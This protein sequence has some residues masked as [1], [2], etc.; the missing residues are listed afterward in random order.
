LG[1]LFVIIFFS[2][3]YIK[4]RPYAIMFLVIPLSLSLI[5]LGFFTLTKQVDIKLDH[6]IYDWGLLQSCRNIP[7]GV[8]CRPAL[9]DALYT[10][11]YQSRVVEIDHLLAL[12]VAAVWG[13][14]EDNGWWVLGCSGRVVETLIGPARHWTVHYNDVSPN[15]F[16]AGASYIRLPQ[17]LPPSEELRPFLE[18]EG[19]RGLAWGGGTWFSGRAG[20][21]QSR[22]F[23]KKRGIVSE[24]KGTAYLAAP[25]SWKFPDLITVNG[26][27]YT[28]DSRG[29][30]V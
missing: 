11:W 3:V 27:N 26:P 6:K 19:L 17:A 18:A 9:G 16:F 20:P 29:D 13:A 21:S 25:S 2:V 23:H 4:S 24:N 30:L 1:I 15:Q 7:P 12:D 28:D 22:Q 8:C 14:R 10:Y 5:S